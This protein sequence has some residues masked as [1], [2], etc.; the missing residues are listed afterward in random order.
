MRRAFLGALLGLATC[1]SVAG[2]HPEATR[3]LSRPPAPQPAL[4]LTA[5]KTTLSGAEAP[6]FSIAFS[7]QG[8]APLQLLKPIDGAEDGMRCV[9]YEWKVVRADGAP[10]KPRSY[11]RCGNS[12]SIG[13]E[14]FETVEP[15]ANQAIAANW[16]AG[17]AMK[18][19]LSPKGVY[20]VQLT[21]TFTLP[22]G[23]LSPAP[24]GGGTKPGKAQ[25]LLKQTHECTIASNW[26]EF[27]RE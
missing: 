13:V 2:C 7:N 6:K 20:R 11:G 4:H 24:F 21:Y 1:W 14:D 17:P 16:L 23:D 12:N 22:D 9:K 19:D 8:G 10:I 25:E 3:T 18:L 26:V 5:Q 27:T 15:G